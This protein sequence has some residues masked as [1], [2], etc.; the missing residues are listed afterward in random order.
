M[1]CILKE[2][3]FKET[4]LEILRTFRKGLDGVYK[5]LLQRPHDL[6]GD[7]YEVQARIYLAFQA[8]QIF[9]TANVTASLKQIVSYVGYYVDKALSDAQ[10]IGLPMTLRNFKD[11][12]MET[13]H[14][15]N[16]KSSSIRNK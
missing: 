8:V 16:K 4:L 1:P 15:E 6:T 3:G 5:N 12:I 9:G 10:I 7:E 11:G 14:K 2:T 13:A